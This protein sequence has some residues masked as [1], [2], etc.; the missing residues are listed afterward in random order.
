MATTKDYYEVLGVARDAS[1]KEI[2]AAYRKLARKYHPDVNKNDPRAEE[3]F[4]EVAEAFAVLSDADKRAKYD[5]GGREAFGPGFD[6]FAGARTVDF[7]FGMGDLSDLFSMFGFGGGA[8]GATR[9]RRRTRARARR[10]EDLHLELSVPFLQA[11]EGAT[12]ELR[13]PR[14]TACEDCRGS[15]TK[16]GTGER[17]CPDCNGSGRTEQQRGSMRVSLTCPRCGGAG[18]LPG[19]PCPRC[20]GTGLRPTDEPVKV[21]IPAGIDD[22]D[23]LRL[24]GKGH[25]GA[26]GAPPGDA[27]LTVRVEPHPILRREGRDLHVDV[28]VGITRAALGGQIQVPT[29]D[30][31][32]MI[33]IPEGTPSG[34]R[35]R[36]RGRG[37][38]AS[39]KKPAG[40]L[41]AVI[42]IRPP[43]TLDERSRELLRELERHLSSS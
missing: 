24:S 37:V 10:G 41:Y 27:F 35:F 34:R 38:P 23:T 5:R 40:D 21:R 25:G 9:G 39:G 30:G 43:D 4:K 31:H 20:G 29:L 26:G 16:P 1:E 7:D 8:T 18:R 12:I 22:G 32:A 17:T 36:L 33:K 15:G 19:D 3:K 6:P 42:Q 11:V 28:P 2:K 13:M 14:H